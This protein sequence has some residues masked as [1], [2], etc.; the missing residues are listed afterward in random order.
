MYRL[1]LIG[2]P[3]K[4]S[5]SP[6]LH[7]QFLKEF[8]VRGAYELYELLEIELGTFTEWVKREGLLGFNVT[9][10]YK[11]AIIPHLDRLDFFA[12]EMNAVNTVKLMNGELVG[13]NTDGIGYMEALR[14][15]KPD[16]F[17]HTNK[18]ILI[19]GAGGAAKGIALA[20]NGLENTT[21]NIANRTEERALELA[22][23]LKKSHVYSLEEA[24]RYLETFD[25]IIQTTTVG[26][27][28][29]IDEQVIRLNRVKPTAIV[30]DIVY[31]PKWTKF[32]K[33]ANAQGVYVLFGIDMLIYQA[34]KSF[35]I[36]TGHR[37]NE[38]LLESLKE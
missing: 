7:K 20:L 38:K 2:N 24:E 22:K 11:E 27:Q 13:Y 16:F 37:P 3:I 17:D 5:K 25:L 29:N 26:M 14:Q 15:F 23:K 28:P 1:G 9:V 6:E 32:L 31:Q 8:N 36:W 21:I 10:P 33:Q 34:A 30:S 35:E 19:I 4:H 18:E 12:K